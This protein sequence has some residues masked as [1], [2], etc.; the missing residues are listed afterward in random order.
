M[1][2]EKMNLLGSAISNLLSLHCSCIAS[3]TTDTGILA[4]ILYLCSE[5]MKKEKK[6]EACMGK[7]KLC[8]IIH[9]TTK[10][11]DNKL[12]DMQQICSFIEWQTQK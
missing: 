7:D 3:E 5:R 4:D 12:L 9:L 10:S 8:T 11:S 2:T 6:N 1:Y